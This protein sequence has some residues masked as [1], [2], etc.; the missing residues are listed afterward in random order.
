MWKGHPKCYRDSLGDIL[1]T[2][3]DSDIGYSVKVDLNYPDGI[4]QNTEKFPF[5][6]L[7]KFNLV[8]F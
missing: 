1:N 8:I 2:T 4:K 5:C 7:N 3:E 6:P